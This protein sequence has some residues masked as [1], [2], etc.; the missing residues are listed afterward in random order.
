MFELGCHVIDLV[1]GVLG[2]PDARSR[3]SPQ[4]SSTLDDD[5]LDNMLAVFEYPRATATRE[6]ERA[7][8]RRRR[9]AAPR[10]LRHRG[11]VPHPAARQP[12]GA[13]VACRRPRGEYKKGYQDVTFPKYTRY[14][15][16]AADMARIIRGEKQADFSAE[17]DLAVQETLLK[18][19]GLPLERD[20]A[21]TGVL[22]V[23]NPLA[24]QRRRRQRELRVGTGRYLAGVF[25]QR[26]A[27]SLGTPG[28]WTTLV[29]GWPPQ[30]YCLRPPVRLRRWRSRRLRRLPWAMPDTCADGSST[31][32]YSRDV[33]VPTTAGFSID[34]SQLDRSG[35]RRRNGLAVGGQ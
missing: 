27:E 20:S 13:R 32:Q 30:V 28:G 2:K 21:T 22:T 5:L 33:F 9:P 29:L 6:V 8:S 35:N 19:C 17:H 16:D 4:H 23:I 18:A 25:A 10:R 15:A 3:R 26:V 12:V 7:G 31:M 1:V 24:L 11:H 34:S 14:V